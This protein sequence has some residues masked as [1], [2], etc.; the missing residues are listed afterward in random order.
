MPLDE[1]FAIG[2]QAHFEVLAQDKSH[3]SET[4]LAF[5]VFRKTDNKSAERLKN[6]QK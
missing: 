1:W 3:A 5:L 2:N 6:Q 4:A